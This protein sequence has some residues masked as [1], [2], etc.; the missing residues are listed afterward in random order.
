MAATMDRRCTKAAVI[1]MLA[2][3]LTGSAALAE[4]IGLLYADDEVT[5]QEVKMGL[6]SQPV[7]AGEVVTMIDVRSSTPDVVALKAFDKLHV[8]TRQ[9]PHKSWELG[10]VLAAPSGVGKKTSPLLSVLPESGWRP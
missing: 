5:A 9:K 6:E 1:A 8:M 3:L 2:L 7:F 4:G 10:D